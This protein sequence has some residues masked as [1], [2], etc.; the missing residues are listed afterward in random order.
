MTV[1]KNCDKV[2]VSGDGAWERCIVQNV[3]R[4]RRKIIGRSCRRSCED[5]QCQELGQCRSKVSS[6]VL[7]PSELLSDKSSIEESSPVRRRR[8][9]TRLKHVQK[10]TDGSG[11]ESS[12]QIIHFYWSSMTDSDTPSDEIFNTSRNERMPEDSIVRPAM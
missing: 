3:Y 7:G 9:H 1:P 10:A 8:R 4:N 6:T 2:E 12:D 5:Y 11:S